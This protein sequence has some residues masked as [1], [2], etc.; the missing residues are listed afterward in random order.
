M[1]VDEIQ[2]LAADVPLPPPDLTVSEWADQ[3]RRL[4]SE[5]AAE[6]GEWRTDRAPYQRAVM[7]AMGPSSPYETVV[8]MWAAQSGKSSLLENFLGYIIELDPGPVLLVEPR[9]VDAEAFSKDRLAPMLRD[10]PC[11]RGKVADAR[12]RD[13]NNTILHKK[14]LGG[15]ITLA[16]RT[17]PQ[18]WP[19]DRSATA[20]STKWTA[21]RQARAAKAI[22]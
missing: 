14:F 6:K 13:S 10:T 12:S 15:S 3:N 8:M 16:G 5:S 22:R 18:A 21:I 7:D 1:R 19:C 17:R 4:S 20:G 2:I 9:E 11:L